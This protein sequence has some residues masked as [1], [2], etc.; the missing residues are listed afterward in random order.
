MWD[1]AVWDSKSESYNH[2]LSGYVCHCLLFA[3]ISLDLSLFT[4]LFTFLFP[5]FPQPLRTDKLYFPGNEF[6]FLVC[7]FNLQVQVK[8]EPSVW[9]RKSENELTVLFGWP[10]SEWAF[11]KIEQL[12][13]KLSHQKIPLS[14]DSLCLPIRRGW[15]CYLPDHWSPP[16]VHV[17]ELTFFLLFYHENTFLI[18]SQ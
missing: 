5:S 11:L 18:S 7:K 3:A 12:S 14:L 4:G 15:R 2:S 13:A 6:T 9:E 10:V 16:Y 1:L 17:W 8:A